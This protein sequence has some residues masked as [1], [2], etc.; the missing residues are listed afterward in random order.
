MATEPTISTAASPCELSNITPPVR[1][2]IPNTHCIIIIIFHQSSKGL[3]V[4]DDTVGACHD[5]GVID[6]EIE[7]LLTVA[8]PWEI[9]I[10]PC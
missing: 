9:K 8:D 3:R 6:D 4:V 1:R 10:Y 7:V 2:L 5:I